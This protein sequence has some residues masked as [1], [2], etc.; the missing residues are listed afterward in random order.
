[1]GVSERLPALRVVRGAVAAGRR[2][3][4]GEGAARAEW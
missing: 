3:A 1:V 2:V 4:R